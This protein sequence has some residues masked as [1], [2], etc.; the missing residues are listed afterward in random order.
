MIYVYNI[1]CIFCGTF[2]GETL[3]C[4]VHPCTSM[5]IPD[6]CSIIL[7]SLRSEPKA[8]QSWSKFL[9]T[10]SLEVNHFSLDRSLNEKKKFSLTVLDAKFRQQFRLDQFWQFPGLTRQDRSSAA[11]LITDTVCC[12]FLSVKTISANSMRFVFVASFTCFVSHRKLGRS[13]SSAFSIFAITKVAWT[14]AT[15]IVSC[16]GK[17]HQENAVWLQY[18]CMTSVCHPRFFSFE[19]SGMLSTSFGQSPALSCVSSWES[20][21]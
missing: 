11:S 7:F 3:L 19:Y 20:C 4:C 1:L 16:K 17:G 5:Y 15:R 2:L 13:G 9:A 8:W 10:V 18:D 6:P 21:L 12:R 14:Q